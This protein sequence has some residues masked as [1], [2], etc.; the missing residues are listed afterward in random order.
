MAKLKDFSEEL[1]VSLIQDKLL[2][3]ESLVNNLDIEEP[4][5]AELK[6]RKMPR[7]RDNCRYEKVCRRLRDG[8][9]KCEREWVCD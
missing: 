3:I 4:I 9:I 7:S 1:I 8:S 5:Y 2:E 6:I